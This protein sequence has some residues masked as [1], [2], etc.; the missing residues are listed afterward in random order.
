MKEDKEKLYLSQLR[1]KSQMTQEEIA[2]QLGVSKFTWR[3]WEIG[4]SA[5]N[6]WELQKIKKIFNVA[7]DDIKILP[8]DT[9]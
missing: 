6:L 7:I 8:K 1:G 3:N 2:K 9:V 5:P 4:K